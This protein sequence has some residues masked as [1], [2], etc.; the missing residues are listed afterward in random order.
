MM[1]A[2]TSVKDVPCQE[3]LN[4]WCRTSTWILQK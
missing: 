4:R 3:R 2:K 1:L